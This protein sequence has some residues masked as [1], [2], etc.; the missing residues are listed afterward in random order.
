MN[1]MSPTS[2]EERKYMIHVLYASAV[3]SLIY[4]MVCKGFYHKLS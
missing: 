3:G 2:V 1:I 4:A